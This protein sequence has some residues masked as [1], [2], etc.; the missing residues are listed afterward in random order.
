M[1][2]DGSQKETG[3]SNRI[4]KKQKYYSDQK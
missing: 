1:K 4:K 2:E 3:G